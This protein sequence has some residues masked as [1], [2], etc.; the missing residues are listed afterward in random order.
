MYHKLK[1]NCTK[2]FNLNDENNESFNKNTYTW[3]EL[4]R[5]VNPSGLEWN[6]YP[7]KEE[8]SLYNFTATYQTSKTL[9]S[10]ARQKRTSLITN[11]NLH[12]NLKGA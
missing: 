1:T 5:T 3:K 2:I 12:A 4:R 6:N 7:H 11:P 9:L 8:N 10:K